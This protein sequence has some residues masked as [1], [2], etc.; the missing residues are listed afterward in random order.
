MSDA[1]NQRRRI[2]L[3]AGPQWVPLGYFQKF[4]EARI[5][6]AFE[7]DK[8]AY[9]VLG[10]AD[11]VDSFAQNLLASICVG[12]DFDRVIIYNKGDKD[13]RVSPNFEL[14]NGFESYPLR[15]AAMAEIATETIVCL[16]LYGGAVSGT[17]LPLLTVI[18]SD[19]N[20]KHTLERFREHSERWDD[21]VVK[22]HIVPLYEALYPANLV[23]KKMTAATTIDDDDAPETFVWFEMH[24]E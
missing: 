9:F 7:Q 15:D 1:I 24:P 17:V 23:A 22:K 8:S 13:G 14:V 16:P 3:I 6:T 11:G 21:A 5:R 12:D 20:A 4:Y 2:I 19:Q 10:A 18:D